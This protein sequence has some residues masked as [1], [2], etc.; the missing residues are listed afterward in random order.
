M[1]DGTDA[2]AVR[3]SGLKDRFAELPDP[4]STVNRQHLLV[5]VVA[6]SVCGVL[7]GA[8]GPTAIF[9]WADCAQDWLKKSLE[10]PHGIP[11]RD[12]I[13]RVLQRLQPEAFQS[14]FAEWLNSL[15]GPSGAKF[16]SIDGKTL[17]RS[18]GGRSHD[19]QHQLGA[20]HLVSVWASEQGLTLG[21]IATAEKSNEITAIPLLLDLVDVK[22]AI[23]SIDAMG[24]QKAIA[25]KIIDKGGD[26]VL[27]VKGNQG[28]LEADVRT[29]LDEALENDF[30]GIKVSRHH[31]TET[32]HGRTEQRWY[33]QINVPPAR[34][35][36]TQWKG[37]RTL[38]LVVRTREADGV[39]T[40][41]VQY[42][43]SS[44]KRNVKTF[45]KAV[46]G[47]WSIENT[48]HWSL[49]MTFREDESRTRDR[50]VAENLAWLRR[51]TLGL[52]KQH[53]SK[54]HSLV[55][56]RRMAGWNPAFLAEIL[57]GTKT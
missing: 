25:A 9:T 2:I 48:C 42:Y 13:R 11:S 34:R 5:D 4:R 50:H 19:E 56:K 12:C 7:A 32:H 6:I 15:V 39:E 10:L 51:F 43:I 27:P 3:M 52:I 41:D 16:L 44:L 23:V 8:D 31:T 46:R 47:H 1:A 22:D 53:P 38:G 33:Y 17:R 54:K 57:F 26:Y 55:M 35:G 45:A 36:L 40:G 18:Y 24:T 30:K 14:C 37:L 29:L 20:L 21:Q 28:S 49:D